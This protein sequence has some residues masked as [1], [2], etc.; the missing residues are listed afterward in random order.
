M[1]VYGI[2]ARQ[3]VPL[4]TDYVKLFAKKTNFQPTA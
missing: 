2:I 4:T 3:K 1:F